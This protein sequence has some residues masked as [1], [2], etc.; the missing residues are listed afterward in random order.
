MLF[1]YRLIW[2]DNTIIR[3][4]LTNGSDIGRH[5][6][7]NGAT[8]MIAYKVDFNYIVCFLKCQVR[9]FDRDYLLM[10]VSSLM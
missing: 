3:S 4:S 9:N 5:V 7:T 1:N 10:K 6:N 2:L 8:K